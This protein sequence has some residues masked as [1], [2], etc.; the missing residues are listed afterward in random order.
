MSRV[1]VKD[2]QELLI[3]ES[4]LR[5]SSSLL[6]QIIEDIKKTTRDST[7]TIIIPDLDHGVLTQINDLLVS[8][9]CR[10]SRMEDQQ[11]I[12]REALNLGLYIEN[13]SIDGRVKNEVKI[14]KESSSASTN[15]NL[16]KVKEERKEHVETEKS[17]EYFETEEEIS[18][19]I[20]EELLE[21]WEGNSVKDANTT[22]EAASSNIGSG[23][24]EFPNPVS[25]ID[26]RLLLISGENNVVPNTTSPKRMRLYELADYSGASRGDDDE[27]GL[28]Q[29]ESFEDG[30]LYDSLPDVAT[31]DRAQERPPKSKLKE[32]QFVYDSFKHDFCGDVHRRIDDCSKAPTHSVCGRKHSDFKNC[33]GSWLDL[34]LF[35]EVAV[36]LT[37]FK[38]KSGNINN[39]PPISRLPELQYIYDKKFHKPCGLYHTRIDV[40]DKTPIHDVCGRKHGYA[41]ECDGTWMSL[42]KFESRAIKW[43]STLLY[44]KKLETRDRNRHETLREKRKKTWS[45]RIKNSEMLRSACISWN[46]DGKCNSYHDD[47]GK[48]HRCSFIAFDNDVGDRPCWGRH[49]ELEH[50]SRQSSSPARKS[51]SRSSLA[52]F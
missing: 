21:N 2:S 6:N 5:L 12:K 42:S 27:E 24:Q 11:N 8:G 47:D 4:L 20:K 50:R 13:F 25:V 1:R 15:D 17:K 45:P 22:D 34:D 51:V 7:I 48:V 19:N 49:T 43:P 26:Q 28:L 37:C 31:N 35:E 29:E 9:T 39:K 32:I 46:F 52:R 41:I 33:D 18:I 23:S 36:K 3:S 14:K 44:K 10:I 30:Q 40:C 38:K 16:V